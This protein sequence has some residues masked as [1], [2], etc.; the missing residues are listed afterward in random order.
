MSSNCPPHMSAQTQDD[1]GSA[2]SDAPLEQI[3]FVSI[4]VLDQGVDLVNNVLRD[5]EQM[6]YDSKMLPG[7]TIG[8]HLRHARDYFDL[9]LSCLSRPKPF[10]LNY[11]LRSR[12]VPMET[13]RPIAATELDRTIKQLRDLQEG[14]PPGILEEVVTLEAVTPFKQVMQTTV[15][16]ELWFAAL[17]AIHHWSMI[18]LIAAGEMGIELDPSFG[19]APSTLQHRGQEGI[20]TK[21]QSQQFRECRGK[22]RGV[23][24]N[25]TGQRTPAR[26][27][28]DE[29]LTHPGRAYLTSAMTE[30]NPAPSYIY[31]IL[32]TA[33]ATPL[34]GVFPLSDLD[35]TDGFIHLSVH[36]QLLRTLSRFFADSE[37]V[38]LLKVDYSIVK[39]E[40]KW[41]TIKSGEVFPH[42]YRDL[43]ASD[44]AGWKTLRRS[45]PES[46]GSSGSGWESVLEATATEGWLE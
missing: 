22:K 39:V 10:E 30:P 27:F 40:I 15:G 3:I 18:R 32:P 13:S 2:A 46:S 12:N 38:S 42:L 23:F 45:P 36:S 7:S 9:L 11:D 28:L 21:A 1:L 14:G 29:L 26:A 44:V 43:T 35:R 24:V 20:T 17:H 8:K 16:R 37:E 33:P 41:E 19:I 6:V 25:G 31:K 34:P 4:A 5:D